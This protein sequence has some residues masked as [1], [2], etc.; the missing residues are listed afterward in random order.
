MSQMLDL[1]RLSYRAAGES[2]AVL[3]GRPVPV[4]RALEL[5]PKVPALLRTAVPVDLVEGA[6]LEI[7]VA[8]GVQRLQAEG[9]IGARGAT[10]HSHAGHNH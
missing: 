4:G 5:E 1:V 7:V 10:A 9:E 2:W 6:E 8:L 3:P